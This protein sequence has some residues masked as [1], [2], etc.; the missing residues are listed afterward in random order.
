M[1]EMKKS[2]IFNQTCPKKS[3]SVK[4]SETIV[5]VDRYAGVNRLKVRDKGV[6]GIH[7]IVGAK[8]L[9][10]NPIIDIVYQT[11]TAVEE[12]IKTAS[13]WIFGVIGTVNGNTGHDRPLLLGTKHFQISEGK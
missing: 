13:I 3:G 8:A 12:I 5:C 7:L 2:Q 11:E 6:V 1:I 9:D 10:T 4:K